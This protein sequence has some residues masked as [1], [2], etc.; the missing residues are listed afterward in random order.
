MEEAYSE[1]VSCRLLFKLP[2]KIVNGC[3]AKLFG[4]LRE[5]HFCL[6]G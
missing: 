4:N 3:V 5:I 1:G 6:C 2:G